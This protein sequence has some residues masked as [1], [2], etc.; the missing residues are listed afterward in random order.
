MNFSGIPTELFQ[1]FKV[2]DDY[3]PMEINCRPPAGAILYMMNYSVD[4]DLYA[5]YAQMIA[6]GGTAV[7]SEKKYCCYLGRRDKHYVNSHYGILD[8][9]G[10]CLVEYEKNPLIFQKAM[11]KYRYILRPVSESEIHQLSDFILRTL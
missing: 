11:G 5:A 4:D 2:G 9:F 1:F 8:R 7:A 3:K 6:Y 10:H